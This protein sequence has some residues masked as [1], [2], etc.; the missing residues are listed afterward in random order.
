MSC[1]FA[2]QLCSIGRSQGFRVGISFF[3]GGGTSFRD[4]GNRKIL[5]PPGTVVTPTDPTD[6]D[7]DL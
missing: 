6:P 2:S 3:P 1:V 7:P 5:F 4:A